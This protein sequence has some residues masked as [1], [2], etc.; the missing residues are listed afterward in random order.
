MDKAKEDFQK[1]LEFEP[2]N[3]EVKTVSVLVLFFFFPFLLFSLEEREKKTHDYTCTFPSLN[4]KEIAKL[5]KFERDQRQ[6]EEFARATEE[7]RK[8]IDE[9]K[10]A[11]VRSI[12]ILSPNR[13][14]ST[15][16]MQS[17][18]IV[19]YLLSCIYCLNL[20]LRKRKE[21]FFFF[22]NDMCSLF[23]L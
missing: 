19:Y 17:F 6:K 8:R 7:G 22:F 5:N 1:A 4:L 10:V 18:L 14:P 11:E 20:R 15:Q 13:I 3:K 21:I 12:K 16:R 23:F 2:Q 9:T